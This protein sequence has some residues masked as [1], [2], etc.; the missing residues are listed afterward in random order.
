MALSEE[1]QMSQ[2]QV[3]CVNF[4]LQADKSGTKYI[5]YLPLVRRLGLKDVEEKC[6]ESINSTSLQEILQNQDFQ[7]AD[8]GCKLVIVLEKGKRL[9]GSVIL[10]YSFFLMPLGSDRFLTIKNISN[11]KSNFKIKNKLNKLNLQ[12]LYN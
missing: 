7:D 9:E 5:R 12:K 8:D 11:S 3:S 6:L 4:I 2:L 1:Y 10:F